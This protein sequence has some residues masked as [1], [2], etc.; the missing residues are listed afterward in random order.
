MAPLAFL[1][2]L[3][4]TDLPSELGS[5]YDRGPNGQTVQFHQGLFNWHAAPPDGRKLHHVMIHPCWVMHPLLRGRLC[6]P[7]PESNEGSLN[8]LMYAA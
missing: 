6:R 7:R 5:H 4:R 3:V 1:F 2:I 8:H